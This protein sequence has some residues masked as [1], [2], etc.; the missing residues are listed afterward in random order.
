M[1]NI[2][3]DHVLVVYELSR[4]LFIHLGKEL[5]RKQGLSSG[6]RRIPVNKLKRALEDYDNMGIF[7]RKILST[8]Q[9]SFY[10][11]LKKRKNQEWFYFSLFY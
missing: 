7:I 10:C 8:C 1:K 2:K 6:K 3:K 5:K 4:L 11:Y 9:L